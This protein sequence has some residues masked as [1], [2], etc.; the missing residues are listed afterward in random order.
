[1][2]TT[3][4]PGG[5][6]PTAPA[7]EGPRSTAAG[8]IPAPREGSPAEDAAPQVPHPWGPPL[9]LPG[10]PR[11]IWRE[12]VLNRADELVAYAVSMDSAPGAPAARASG[13]RSDAALDRCIAQHL[14]VACD[15]ARG[16]SFWRA[17]RSA[18]CG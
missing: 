11:R 13:H 6:L 17:A 1:M 14:K 9:P 2:T 4:R 5:A 15:A 18:R 8:P 16:V 12:Q 10:K 3:N 7:R